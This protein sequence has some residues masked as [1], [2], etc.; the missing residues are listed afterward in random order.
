[1]GESPYGGVD[2]GTISAQPFLDYMSAIKEMALDP[3]E[4]LRSREE[5]ELTERV[6]AAQA[7]RGLDLSGVG[8]GMETEALSDFALDWQDRMLGRAATG[9]SAFGSLGA[10]AQD[11]ASRGFQQAGQLG[12]AM[13]RH[14]G[15]GGIGG[16]APSFTRTHTVRD[17]GSSLYRR[18]GY[19]PGQRYGR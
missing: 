5:Q 11:I 19:I 2:P 14:P 1:M 8:A 15:A 9:A 4:D 6:R 18:P 7:A 10:G 13:F 3:Q 17:A 12:S 16:G